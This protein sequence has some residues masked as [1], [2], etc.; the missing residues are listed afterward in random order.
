MP[1]KYTLLNEP[2]IQR[3]LHEERIAALEKALALIEVQLMR[4]DQTE[5]RDYFLAK[6]REAEK[7]LERARRAASRRAEPDRGPAE[8]ASSP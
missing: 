8:G 7:M 1:A 2:A 4:A 5:R 6:R 3:M